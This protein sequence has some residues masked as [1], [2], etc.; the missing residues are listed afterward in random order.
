MNQSNLKSVFHRLYTAILNLWLYIIFRKQVRIFWRRN[1]YLPNIAWPVF[2]HEK[3]LWRKIFD[4]YPLFEIFSDKIACKKYISNLIPEI[5]IPNTL[6]SGTDIREASPELFS[7]PII[8]KSNHGYNHNYIF[9]GEDLDLTTIHEI[10]QKWLC[11]NHG[12][13]H[14]EWAYLNLHKTI[15]I[16]ELIPSFD[17][18][19][20]DISLSCTNGKVLYVRVVT[21]NKTPQRVS[22]FFDLEGKRLYELNF[23]PD[24]RDVPFVSE[25]CSLEIFDKAVKYAKILSHGIDYAR[26]DFMSNGKNLYAGEITVYPNA[27]HMRVSLPGEVGQNTIINDNWDLK[28]S[29]FLRTQ[30]SGWK[31]YYATLLKKLL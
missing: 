4:H 7:Q 2:Y 5:N 1:G 22:R 20:L 29:W 28:L 24:P 18:V 27:G 13:T 16:E 26:F 17:S 21:Q 8:I 3:V 31:R 19:F 30:Q 6:W 14:Y 15:F 12:T 25:L 11:I 23:K 10:T 9:K